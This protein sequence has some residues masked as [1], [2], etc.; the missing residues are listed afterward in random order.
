MSKNNSPSLLARFYLY[1]KQRF[2]IIFLLIATFPVVLSS[3]VV[4]AQNKAGFLKIT[5]ILIA[6]LS[7]FFHIRVTDEYRDFR[8]DSIYHNDRPVQKGI[9]PLADLKKLDIVAAI[10][11][12]AVAVF[13]NIYIFVIALVLVA[14]TFLARKEFFLAEKIRK[15]FFIYNAVNLIQMLLLQIFVYSFFF[16]SFYLNNVIITH[17]LFIATGTFLFEFLRKIKTPQTESSGKDTYS[18]HLGFGRSIL[19]YALIVSLNAVLFFVLAAKMSLKLGLWLPTSLLF[20]VILFLY[21]YLHWIKKS[22]STDKLLQ[23]NSLLVYALF[24]LLIYFLK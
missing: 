9:M 19:F 4:V 23:A 6:S 14:Y 22:E 10:I 13:S 15:H 12:L 21:A 7:Y 8:H 20:V 5:L 16:K 1:Q 24:N 3:E 17:F 11:L 2:P 18:W